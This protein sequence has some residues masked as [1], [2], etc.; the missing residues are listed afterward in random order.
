VGARAVHPVTDL[1][2]A[3]E[4][5]RAD[6]I[7]V[8]GGFAGLAAAT[9]LAEQGRRVLVLE[10]RPT[11]GGRATAFT[12][13]ATGERVDN[14]QHVLL[15]CYRDTFRFLDR[16]GASGHVQVQDRLT[17]DMIDR[18]GRAS[19]LRCPPLWPPFNLVAGLMTWSALGWHDRLAALRMPRGPTAPVP[20]GETVR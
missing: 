7:V 10:A 19:R 3:S 12:D 17:V 11:L 6:A 13:P 16:I 2:R 9:R 8:G 1:A 5:S 18:E 4:A 20:L 15:G 14:G